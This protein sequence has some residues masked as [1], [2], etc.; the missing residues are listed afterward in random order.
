LIA[1]ATDL[2]IKLSLWFLSNFLV[3][4]TLSLLFS[5]YVLFYIFSFKKICREIYPYFCSIAEK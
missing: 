4:F 2:V 5:A 1:F 3:G